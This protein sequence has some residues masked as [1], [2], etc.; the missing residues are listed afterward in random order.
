MR[1]WRLH[2]HEWDL[3]PYKSHEKASLSQPGEGATRR[4]PYTSQETVPHQTPDLPTPQSCTPHCP[5]LWEINV[6]CL[7]HPVYGNL[8]KQPELTK[9]LSSQHVSFTGQMIRHWFTM[10]CLSS[11]LKKFCTEWAWKLNL[12]KHTTIFQ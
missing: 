1:S 7:S 10:I 5:E 12:F 9:N 4:H 3:Y 11:S 6:Y 2:T 8:L